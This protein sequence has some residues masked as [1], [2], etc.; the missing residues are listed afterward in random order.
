MLAV[1]SFS[2]DPYVTWTFQVEGDSI[3]CYNGHYFDSVEPAL[4]TSRS[5]QNCERSLGGGHYRGRR[6]CSL[7]HTQGRVRASDVNT[8]GTNVATSQYSRYVHD[9]FRRPLIGRT[10]VKVFE[11]NHQEYENMG[12]YPGSHPAI[13]IQLDDGTVVV[14]ARDRN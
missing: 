9:E 11:F 7:S 8:G 14:P 12:W 2:P 1:A 4:L 5:E 10:I 3:E 13:V 6:R